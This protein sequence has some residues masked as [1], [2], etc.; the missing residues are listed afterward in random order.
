MNKI[1]NIEPVPSAYSSGETA[2]ESAQS[3]F[4]P[5]VLLQYWS[6]VLR[7]RWIMLVTCWLAST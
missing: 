5:P 1:V 2:A 6:K 7:W 3:R 4:L